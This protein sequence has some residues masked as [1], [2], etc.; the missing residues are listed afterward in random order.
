MGELT[1]FILSIPFCPCGQGF[2]VTSEASHRALA[3]TIDEAA[4]GVGTLEL[5]EEGGVIYTLM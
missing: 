2:P 5:E 4:A 1:S 3:L